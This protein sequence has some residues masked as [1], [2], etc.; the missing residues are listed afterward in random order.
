MV[1]TSQPATMK[2]WRYSAQLAARQLAK[3]RAQITALE[4]R[5]D[6]SPGELGA[7]RQCWLQLVRDVTMLQRSFPTGGGVVEVTDTAAV[8]PA[9]TTPETP[10]KTVEKPPTAGGDQVATVTLNQ[11][12]DG[13][14]ALTIDCIVSASAQS[15]EIGRLIPV[16][17]PRGRV[18]SSQLSAMQR[19]PGE[20]SPADHLGDQWGSADKY[21]SPGGGRRRVQ[22]EH[23]VHQQEASVKELRQAALNGDLP[24]VYTC[25]WNPRSSLS[26]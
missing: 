20:R 3:L 22:T 26:A 1:V 21:A 9:V 11:R 14:F 15:I 18:S 6:R 2:D 8:V 10:V 12:S 17:T 7:A 16:D 19:S 23:I 24:C 4:E 13:S 25:L 5:T